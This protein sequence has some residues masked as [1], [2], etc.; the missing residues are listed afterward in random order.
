MRLAGAQGRLRL[1]LLLDTQDNSAMAGRSAICVRAHPPAR[2]Q[3]AD[4]TVR[5]HNPVVDFVSPALT[6]R[7]LNGFRPRLTVIGVHQGLGGR[8]GGQLLRWNAEEP[9]AGRRDRH[10]AGRDVERPDAD[11]H[12][13]QGLTEL[14]DSQRAVV[15]VNRGQ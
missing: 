1:L 5:P 6:Q 4:M 13:V 11:P 14:I 15:I 10:A 3:P 12:I 9:G 7:P 2:A 8:E